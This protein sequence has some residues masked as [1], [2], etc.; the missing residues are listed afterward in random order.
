MKFEKYGFGGKKK[1]SKRNTKE[2]AAAIG[3]SVKK[4]Q[5]Q[6][7]DLRLTECEKRRC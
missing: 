4:G 6:I 2:S 3:S 1:G 5:P 7:N